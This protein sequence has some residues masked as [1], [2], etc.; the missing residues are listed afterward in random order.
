M[1]VR[2]FADLVGRSQS[3]AEKIESGQ[4]EV[5]RLPMLERVAEVLQVNVTTLISDAATEAEAKPGAVEVSAIKSA[6]G[7]YGVLFADAGP[8]VDVESLKRRIEYANTA[9]LASDFAT[10]GRMLPSLIT[11]A[12]KALG[13]GGGAGREAAALAVMVYKIASS[14]LHKF[15]SHEIAWLAADRAMSAASQAGDPVSLARG[16][17]CAARALMSVGQR[18]E[19]VELV[20]TAFGQLEPD[21]ATASPELLALV[22]MML[23]AAEIAAAREG[24]AETCMDMHERAATLAARLGDDYDHPLTAFGMPNVEAHRLASLVRLGNGP[25]AVAYAEQVS[26]EHLNRLPRERK[27]NYLLDLAE[28]HRQCGQPTPAVKAL[29]L[30]D[31][32]SPQE[33]R[34]RPLGRDLI[35]ALLAEEETSRSVSLRQV[36]VRA[37]LVA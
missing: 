26:D 21:L 35:A 36:A 17:R 34:R 6:L 20:N 23:L 8:P 5:V 7:S 18:K 19:A 1:T 3:W 16:T 32:T 31:L 30:A 22:G 27:A 12:Q 13:Y 25:L 9:F 11:D 29:V 4:R 14:T 28:A 10:V 37:G 33:V 15:G 24:D 2:H